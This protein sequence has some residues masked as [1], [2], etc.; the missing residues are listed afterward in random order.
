MTEP[1]TNS[2]TSPDALAQELVRARTRAGLSVSELHRQSTISRTVIQGYESG[3]FKPGAREIKL[4][5]QVLR[6]SPNRLLF[7]SE[8]PFAAGGELSKL[9]GDEASALQA[10]KLALLFGM[11]SS[12]EKEA[13]LTLMQS[14]LGSRD[15]HKL[16][17]ALAAVD[18]LAEQIAPKAESFATTLQNSFSSEEL[19]KM[20][21]SIS[22]QSKD[23]VRK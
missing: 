7:G 13:F 15:R 10:T 16:E 1:K 2:D 19:S 18:A 8:T 3:K 11:L 4:L 20:E 21:A 5:C 9:V 6:I 17:E 14:I 23:A 22:Q 12:I